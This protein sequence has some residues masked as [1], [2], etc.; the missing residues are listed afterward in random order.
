ML[1]KI[2]IIVTIL[3]LLFS[4]GIYVF[5]SKT[6]IPVQ[7]RIKTLE[8]Y[9]AAVFAG[10]CFWC[11]EHPFEKIDGVAEVISGYSGGD[12]VNP[13][14]EEV[15]SGTTGHVESVKVYYNPDKISYEDLLEIFWRQ[16]DPTD[17]GGSFVDRGFQYTSAIFYKSEIESLT[18]INSVET[19]ELSGRYDKPI[20]TRIV[21]LTNF[22]PAEDYHQD[23][24]KKNSLKYNYY[25][26][27]SGRD[28]YI[29]KTW[30]EDKEY[31]KLRT[32]M[33]KYED[34]DKESILKE[35]TSLQF[36]VTQNDGT[37]K[38]FDNEYWENEEEG[39]YVDVVSGEPLF[40][41][42]D[43]YKSD[44]G[45]P[46]FTKPL[47]P[48]NIVIKEDK[49][50]FVTR[51]EVRSRYGDSHLGHVFED[52]PE[53]TGLRYCLNSA[54]IRFIPKEKLIDEGYGDYVKYFE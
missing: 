23:Y 15:S 11:M 5:D 26:S 35:L 48:D 3:I 6:T 12:V 4:L 43:K 25:R 19:L 27:R 2:A 44:T 46:S 47:E 36:E 1:K 51:I 28:E 31:D 20:V 29:D 39:I 17:E 22:Y 54:A 7:S 34:F 53:P 18:A 37:E 8:G 32:K 9:E 41:S 13:T 45:W 14:Y 40:S 49:K 38:P 33:S 50:L 42:K 52:G 24:Y 10:G 21:P 30:G 16:I